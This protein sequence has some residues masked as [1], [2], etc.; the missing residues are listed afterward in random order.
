MFISVIIITTIQF[1]KK[2][3]KYNYHQAIIGIYY[4]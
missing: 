1:Y 3:L 4:L 2:N